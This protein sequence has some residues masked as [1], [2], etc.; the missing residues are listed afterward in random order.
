[1]AAKGELTGLAARM[2]EELTRTGRLVVRA[3]AL[4]KG[5]ECAIRFLL[6]AVLAGADILGGA[7][8][9]AL[10]LVAAAGP[11]LYGFSALLGAVFGYLCFLGLVNSLRYVAAA[12]LIFCVSFAFYDMWFYRRVWFMPLAAALLN[13]VTGFAY[14]A[15][16]RWDINQVVLFGTGLL[17]TGAS[18]CFYHIAFS[19]SQNVRENSE[20]SF[21]QIISLL[22]LGATA[23]IALAQIS[24]PGGFLSLGRTLAALAVMAVA[25]VCGPGGGAIAGIVAGISMD[26]AAGGVFF[27]TVA[28]GL[29]GLMTGL[30]HRQSRLLCAVSYILTNALTV[31]WNWS[32]GPHLSLLYEVFAASVLFLLLPDGLLRRLG[33]L[34][35]QEDVKTRDRHAAA[36][37]QARLD[38]TAGAFHTLYE[39]LRGT[40]RSPGPND[41]NAATIFDRAANRV[42]RTCAL[43]TSCWQRDYISTFHSLND[44]LPAM[45]DRGRGEGADFPVHFSSRCLHFPE[46]L[47][48]ANQELTALLYRRQFNARLQESRQAVCR[49]YEDLSHA[50]QTAA[51]ELG[52]ELTPDPRREKKLCQ[53][54]TACQLEGTAWVCYDSAGHL[55]AELTGP[56]LT[57][58]NTPEEQKIFSALLGCPL[59]EPELV[60]SQTADRLILTQ[61][62]PLM[63]VAGAAARQKDGETVSGDAGAWFRTP[64]GQIYI[65]LCDG[66]GSG[67]D[68]SRESKLAIR[69]LEQFLKAGV[70]PESAL[71]TLNTALFLKND[72]DGGFTTVD[73]LQ[74]DLFT[75]TSALYK[76]G[77]APSYLRRGKKV[78]RI[79]GSALPAGLVSGNYTGPDITRLTLSAGDVVVLISD[80]VTV[81]SDDLWLREALSSFDEKSP[82]ELAHTLI[83]ASGEKGEAADDRTALVVCIAAR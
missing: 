76:F 80:G 9:F 21:R 15:D 75:G 31:L 46:F 78:T 3:P 61:A 52:T 5:T 35:S 83:Q 60:H 49:Q 34:L 81:G 68:A 58:L 14:L 13:G 69:L 53:H 29:S 73:L 55:R 64:E 28:F 66:M 71:R 6:S 39:S 2:R 43:Q 20:L 17:F 51:A 8:P 26:L 48:A 77:A 74:V 25:S 27:Y 45:M 40:F 56:D 72:E 11:G 38:A 1:M 44:A 10:G 67:Q 37:V 19:S 63:A 32:G 70:A 33:A 4:V 54:L 42:C 57:A 82:R 50:L 79:I 36:F 24:L 41:G 16:S 59:R 12:I 30:M 47:A 65:L 18:A 22:V 7:H 62:E 23:L